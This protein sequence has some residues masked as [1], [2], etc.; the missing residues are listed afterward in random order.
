MDRLRPTEGRCGNSGGDRAFF[1][2][3]VHD[4]AHRLLDRIVEAPIRLALVDPSFV[5]GRTIGHAEVLD[6]AFA[7]YVGSN[8][9]VEAPR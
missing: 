9:R 5:T 1:P 7:S 2:R 8:P 3:D 4:R 6:G